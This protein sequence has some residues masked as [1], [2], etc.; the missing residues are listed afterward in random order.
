MTTRTD[1]IV[2]GNNRITK[3][4]CHQVEYQSIE[5]IAALLIMLG[6]KHNGIHFVLYDNVKINLGKVL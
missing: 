2:G 1:L 4:D 6:T 3:F 5:L